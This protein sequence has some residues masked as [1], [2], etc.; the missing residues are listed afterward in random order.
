MVDQSVLNGVYACL[1]PAP[2]D[3][4]DLESILTGAGMLAPVT[5]LRIRKKART[6]LLCLWGCADPSRH[7][8]F[9]ALNN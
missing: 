8:Q 1:M 5:L 7:F 2:F 6:K 3:P 9:L 4:G